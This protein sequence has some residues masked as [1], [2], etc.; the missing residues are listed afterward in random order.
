MTPSNLTPIEDALENPPINFN[1]QFSNSIYYQ[2]DISPDIT[3]NLPPPNFAMHA[4]LNDRV[5][6]AL[7]TLIRSSAVIRQHLHQS[8]MVQQDSTPHGPESLWW[9]DLLAGRDAS[10]GSG[11]IAERLVAEDSGT[12][13]KSAPNPSSNTNNHDTGQR[14]L[15]NLEVIEDSSP[16]VEEDNCWMMPSYEAWHEW[17]IN[18]PN[19][20]ILIVSNAIT[21]SAHTHH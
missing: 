13:H 2:S 17:I 5:H 4:Q 9:N 8:P 19:L 1:A 6:Y 7:S 11:L 3:T 10:I 14:V 21:C 15:D 18:V 12:G 20:A 16:L